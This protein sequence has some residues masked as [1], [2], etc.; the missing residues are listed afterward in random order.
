MIQCFKCIGHDDSIFHICNAKT[1]SVV[2]FLSSNFP[3]DSQICCLITRNPGSNDNIK[4]RDMISNTQCNNGFRLLYF[5]YENIHFSN[6]NA[7]SCKTNQFGA[8][9]CLYVT[10]PSQ[11]YVIGERMI[12][13]NCEGNTIIDAKYSCQNILAINNN[14]YN[15]L[16][17]IVGGLLN[18]INSVVLNNNYPS[19]QIYNEGTPNYDIPIQFISCYTDFSETAQVTITNSIDSMFSVT[20]SENVACMLSVRRK[21]IFP[22]NMRILALSLVN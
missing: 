8:A 18:I 11:D 7:S 2:S 9:C 19:V 21:R 15:A 17:G 3:K 14:A 4:T 20:N 12:C 22:I 1:T 13:R 16:F 6:S 10:E 5:D